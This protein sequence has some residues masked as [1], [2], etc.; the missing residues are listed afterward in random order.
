MNTGMPRLTALVCLFFCFTQKTRAQYESLA[1]LPEFR[2]GTSHFKNGE[3]DKASEN[4]LRA[5][6]TV[7]ADEENEEE[8]KIVA[9]RLLLAL[10]E[11]GGHDQIV[12]WYEENS[13]VVVSGPARLHL[14]YALRDAEEFEKAA[15]LFGSLG[16]IPGA[17]LSSLSENQA[18]CM[19]RSGK[20]SAALRLLEE[21]GDAKT[22]REVFL[23]TGLALRSGAYE[24]AIEYADILIHQELEGLSPAMQFEAELIRARAMT[25]SGSGQQAASDLL[26]LIEGLDDPPQIYRAFEALKDITVIAEL[27]SL[28]KDLDRLQEGP[29]SPDVK[30]AAEYYGALLSNPGDENL[31]VK[32]EEFARENSDHPLG[33]EA[34]IALSHLKPEESGYW[35]SEVENSGAGEFL[36][37]RIDHARATGLFEK[38]AFNEASRNFVKMAESFQGEKR[39]APLY[40]AAIAALFSEDEDAFE[41]LRKR[42]VSENQTSPM[43]GDLLF[44]SGIFFASKNDS[45]AFELLSGFVRDYPDHPSRNEAELAIAELHLNQVPP[46][47]QAAREVL[48]ELSVRRLGIRE[49]ERLDYNALWTEVIDNQST[50]VQRVGEQF[51]TDWPNSVYRAEVSMLIAAH[52]FEEKRF[53]QAKSLFDIVASDF[54]EGEFAESANFFAAKASSTSEESLELWDNVISGDGK[55][56]QAARHE[57][58]LLLLKLNRFDDARELFAETVEL[59]KV[60]EPLMIAA[61]AETGYSWYI[62]ALKNGGDKEMLGNAADSYGRISRIPG[63]SRSW[64]YEAAVRRGK[65]LEARGDATVALEIYKSMVSETE[66][67]SLTLTTDS[68]IREIEWLYRAGFAAIS[69][70]EKNDDWASAIKMADVLSRKNGPR[71]IEASRYADRM[72]LKHWVWE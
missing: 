28:P 4:L 45:R 34:R 20:P 37:A 12:E 72:R 69:V 54:P 21:S 67:L 70:L 57:K 10:W 55:L 61:I 11:S 27:A 65:C 13:S 26:V 24:K 29:E 71:A 59:G 51:L 53:R 16:K 6:D 35:L 64:R 32:L 7:S 25:K 63:V 15:P 17:T 18:Y 62:E 5:W 38:D 22:A 60:G 30:L 52:Y 39:E 46:R 36:Q 31:A 9:S 58:G 43:H 33:Q 40:N 1:D 19:V 23:R 3:F 41:K 48:S 68:P 42:I 66:D 50:E 44:L 8:K 14:A 2:S 56:A 49:N 47:P